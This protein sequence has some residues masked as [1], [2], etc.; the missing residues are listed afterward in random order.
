MGNRLRRQLLLAGASAMLPSAGSANPLALG[1][2]VPWPKLTLLN[3]DVVL[4]RQWQGQAAVLVFF[5]TTCPYCRRHNEHVEKLHQAAQ[6]LPLRV[7]AVAQ[8]SNAEVVKTYVRQHRYHFP[9]TLD[10]IA[11]R[12][13]FSQRQII[14]LTCVVDRASKLRE[15]LP[16]EMFEEDLL[17]MTRWAEAG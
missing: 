11:L 10:S 8:D 4:P 12:P 7:L 6:G 3:G 13:L 17:E 9:V 5:A 1:D 14:P 15:V 16:G 2:A